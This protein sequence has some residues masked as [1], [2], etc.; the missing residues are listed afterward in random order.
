MQ[1]VSREYREAMKSPIRHRGYIRVHIGVVNSRA[2]ENARVDTAGDRLTYFS[3]PDKAFHGYTVDKVY[4]TAEQDFSKVDGSMYF[5]PPAKEN[6]LYNNGIVSNDILGSVSVDFNGITGLD[7]KGLTIDFGEYYPTR[8]TVEYDGGVRSYENSSRIFVTEDVFNGTSFFKITPQEM[9]NGLGRLRIYQ[10]TCGIANT[11]TNKEVLDYSMKDFVSPISETI[12]SQDMTLTVDN[13]NLYYSVDNPDSTIAYM[14]V[15]QEVKTEFGYDLTGNGDFE[16]VKETTTYLKSWSANDTQA[17]FMAT[18]RF[19]NMTGKYY[20]GLYRESGISLYDLAIDVLNDAGITDERE[21]F[22]DPYLKGIIVH[23]PMPAVKHTDALQII[24]NAG[25]CVLYEDRE[26]RIHLKA[27][28]V[29]EMTVTANNQTAY[30]N[31]KNLLK[32]G[33][34]EAYAVCSNDFS[35]LDG[36][37]LFMPKSPADYLGNT[38]YVSNSIYRE[39]HKGSMSQRLSFRLGTNRRVLNEYGYWEGETPRI[40]IIP[41]AAFVAFGLIIRFRNVAPQE[42]HIITYLQDVTVQ[43]FTVTKPDLE[44]VSYD[45]FY[46]FDRMELVF[47]KGYPDAR[48]T[49]DNILI[50]DITDYVLSR[51]YSIKN[52]PTGTRQNRIKSISVQKKTYRRSEDAV[53]ELRQEELILAAGETEQTVYFTNPSYGLSVAIVMDESAGGVADTG[54]NQSVLGVSVSIVEY[55]SYYAKIRFSGVTADDTVVKYAVSGYEYEVDESFLTV[56]HNADGEEKEW[57]NPLISTTQQAKDLEKW[58]AS[59]HLG[60]VEYQITWRGD[61]RVDANDLFYLEL[62]DRDTALVRDYENTLKFSGAWE[63]SIK[64]RKAVLS[65]R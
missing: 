48:I 46:Q 27:S 51:R 56:I 9:V 57:K 12:P 30:S 28:F 8:F 4:A 3:M 40:T 62:K 41:E 42:F 24:A 15:G 52:T 44:Y 34:K 10:F 31:I 33:S 7:I 23:N 47:T 37:L 65:W 29:P 19:D 22:I 6:V 49:I 17:K 61:P 32:D 39:N 26:S 59:Y 35:V 53:K 36:S 20:R 5:L 11:F 55:S 25:R 21:Y 1:K 54:Y 14:E 38:G 64:A 45:E 43:D 18:D 16:W 13:Q 50:G 63:G 60:D 2:Q 58:L